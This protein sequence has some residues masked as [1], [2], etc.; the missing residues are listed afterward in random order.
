MISLHA[1]VSSLARL[2]LNASITASSPDDIFGGLTIYPPAERFGT[3]T[4]V[5]PIL[6]WFFAQR[7]P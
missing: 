5:N 6:T 7:C 2:I 1:L 3:P 4:I